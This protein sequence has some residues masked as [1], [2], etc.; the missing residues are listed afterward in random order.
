MGNSIARNS[1]NATVN[2]ST[3]VTNN[4]MQTCLSTAVQNQTFDCQPPTTACPPNISSNCVWDE[5]TFTQGTQIST[6]CVQNATSNTS[7]SQQVAQNVQQTAMAISASIG[8]DSTDAENVAT[9]VQN[10]STNIVNNYQSTLATG[11]DANIGFF[12]GGCNNQWTYINVEQL[13]DWAQ[14]GVQDTS[15]VNSATQQLSQTISQKATAINLGLIGILIAI[16]LIILALG[17]GGYKLTSGGLKAALPIFLITL[18]AF[19]GYLGAASYY[20]W[21]PWKAKPL[22]QGSSCTNLGS[23]G[24]PCANGQV[25]ASSGN[26]NFCVGQCLTN[27]GCNS[28]QCIGSVPFTYADGTQTTLQNVCGCGPSIGCNS[29]YTICLADGG[30][31]AG[32]GSGYCVPATSCSGSSGCPTG[33]SCLND[34]C[35]P[36][37]CSTNSDCLGTWLCSNGSCVPPCTTGANCPT[38]TSCQQP[39]GSNPPTGM[40]C[41]PT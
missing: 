25:C 27:A 22:N 7:V 39:S 26:G 4:T 35:T 9:A 34:V 18:I 37:S 2:A 28:N 36:T 30:A 14:N 19:G 16:A 32:T 24:P 13:S 21:A 5:S 17:Y 6:S 20:R 15:S 3:N 1:V 41:L 38:G 11:G 31:P 12:G 8:L 40:Y 10:V 33:Q 29:P 23:A